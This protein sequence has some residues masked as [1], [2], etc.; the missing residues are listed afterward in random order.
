M[1]ENTITSRSALFD[2][3]ERIREQGYAQN[4]GEQLKGTRAVS[5]AIVI[6]DEVLGAI[7]IGGPEH[8]LHGDWFETELPNQVGSVSNEIRLDLLYS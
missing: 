6:E 8:R 5:S 2:E 1:T 7:S 4:Y 3:L